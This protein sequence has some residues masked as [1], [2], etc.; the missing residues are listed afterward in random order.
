MPK[1]Q[2]HKFTSHPL[3]RRVNHRGQRSDLIGLNYD[4]VL[5]Y[6]LFTSSFIRSR[7]HPTNPIEA[8]QRWLA[9]LQLISPD[10]HPYVVQG[11]LGIN[12]HL[13][14]EQAGKRLDLIPQFVASPVPPI[15]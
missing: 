5:A 8:K 6:Y 4:V 7:G 14:E 3:Y 10:K 15:L 11:S 12:L 13:T 2:R 1:R 9:H